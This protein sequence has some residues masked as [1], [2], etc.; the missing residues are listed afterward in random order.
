MIKK[1]LV[2]SISFALFTAPFLFR[3]PPQR[4]LRLLYAA[5]FIL[6]IIVGLLAKE[7]QDI[8]TNA[9]ILCLSCIGIK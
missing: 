6:I 8:Y 4:Q 1:L 3:R 9:V 7:Y 2:I 5:L